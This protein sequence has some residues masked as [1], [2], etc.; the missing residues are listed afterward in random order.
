[1][2]DRLPASIPTE[3]RQTWQLLAPL[4]P[5]SLYLGGGTGIAIHLNHRESRDLDFFY[6]H[7]SVDLDSLAK[8]L[9]EAGAFA[10]T[11]TSPGTLRGLIGATKV[12]FLHAD[13]VAPQAPLEPPTEVAG[14]RIAGMKDLLAMK[15]KVLS[16]RGEMRDYFDVKV[17]DERSVLSV[18]EGVALFLSRYR[19]GPADGS[20]KRLIR[21]M[22]FLGDVEEDPA[23]PIERN[24]LVQWWQRRQVNVL[25][26]LGRTTP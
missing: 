23:L 13:E 16:E 14:L 15:M 9:D 12:E 6:H 11:E 2:N 1:M 20:V 25:R 7:D 19:L 26:N 22:G 3:T 5:E 8:R 17:I 18:E 24:E 21:A 10:V 4:L